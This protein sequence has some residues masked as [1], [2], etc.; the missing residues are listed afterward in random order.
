MDAL[1]ELGLLSRAEKDD[2][3]RALFEGK[4]KGDATL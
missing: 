2:L 4:D 1:P 3:I